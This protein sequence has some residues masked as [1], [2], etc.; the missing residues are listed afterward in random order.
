[1][2]CNFQIT[3]YYCVLGHS[4]IDCLIHFVI[5]VIDHQVFDVLVSLGLFLFGDRSDDRRLGNAK[6]ATSRVCFK[7]KRTLDNN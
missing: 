4:M 6:V 3:F 5:R 1:M 2:S 7:A